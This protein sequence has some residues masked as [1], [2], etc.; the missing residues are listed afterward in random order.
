MF[1]L[2]LC[3][4]FP[5]GCGYAALYTDARNRRRSGWNR[6]RPF[7]ELAYGRREL[8]APDEIEVTGNDAVVLGKRS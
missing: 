5:F 8:A 2:R 1:S 6:R 7:D 3:G 4:E